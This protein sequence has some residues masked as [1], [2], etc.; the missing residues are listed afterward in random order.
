MVQLS[1]AAAREI[2]RFQRTQAAPT[3]LFRLGVRS[4]GCLGTIYTINLEAASS[5]GDRIFE[6]EQIRIVVDPQ[7]LPY[8]EGVVLDYSEDLMGGAFRF[9]NPKAIATCECGHSFVTA[10]D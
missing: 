2:E 4:G 9:Q 8:V 7:S 3:A 10:D 1:P 5:P 6:S